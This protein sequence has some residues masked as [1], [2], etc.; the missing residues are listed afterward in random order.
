MTKK[1]LRRYWGWALFVFVFSAT[2]NNWLGPPALM[3]LSAIIIFYFL[4]SAPAWCGAINRDK[5]TFC[6]KNSYGLL[7]S[8]GL[9]QHKWQKVKLTFVGYYWAKLGKALRDEP[10]EGLKTITAAIGF[11][12]AIV[13]ML[14]AL[15][16][17]LSG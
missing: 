13:A 11:V 2:I 3:L 9:E 17:Y 10:L 4:L 16:R 6:R 7:R 15:V 12:A 8:C 1:A 5:K 14:T